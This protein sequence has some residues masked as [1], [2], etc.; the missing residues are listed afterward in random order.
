MSESGHGQRQPLPTQ[1][2][3]LFGLPP[4]RHAEADLIALAALMDLAPDPADPKDGPDEEE[5]PFV[6][7]GYTYLGQF[8]DHDLTFDEVSDLGDLN[9]FHFAV[10]SRTPSFDL[11]NVYGG[12]PDFKPFLYEQKPAFTGRLLLGEPISNGF[13]DVARNAEGLALIGDPRNDE[14]ALVVQVHA[15]VIRFHNAMVGRAN[16]GRGTAPCTGRDAFAWAQRQTRFHYQRML[17]DDYLPR[18]VDTAA[19]GVAGLFGT[20]RAGG[21][22]EPTLF[23]PGAGSEMPLEFSVAAYRFGHSMIRPGY[24]LAG[25]SDSQKV[26]IFS[27]E[28]GGLRGFRRLDPALGIDWRLFVHPALPAGEPLGADGQKA[29]NAKGLGRV[30]FAYK[31]DPMVVDPITRLPTVVAPGLLPDEKDKPA[32]LRSLPLRNLLRG[33]DFGLP[34]GEAVARALGLPDAAILSD[35]QLTV[36]DQRDDPAGGSNFLPARRIPLSQA[37][38]A[39]QGSTPLWFYILAEAEQGVIAGMA[40]P[41]TDPELLGTRLGA[42]GGTIVAETFVGLMLADPDSVLNLPAPW[43][44]I[45]GRAT[46]SFPELLAEGGVA[47]GN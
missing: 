11:D 10:D 20:L 16:A 42:V 2:R 25:T 19:P 38:P 47:F 40:A 22:P 35:E 28:N 31:I 18:I 1:F 39:M 14:N 17:L 8:V 9:T 44:S 33:N 5:N 41:G 12:G 15:A 45:N 4:A 43:R 26:A 32:L 7:A 27:G 34:S 46:F 23:R 3:S 37:I 30:Q 24:R 21:R 13:H 29:N 36:R 6:P